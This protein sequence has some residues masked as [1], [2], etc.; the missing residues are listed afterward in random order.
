[1]QFAFFRG[2][3]Q[4]LNCDCTFAL[5]SIIFGVNLGATKPERIGGLKSPPYS[6][7]NKKGILVPPIPPV[8]GL[9]N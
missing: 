8:F 6:I 2:K 1:V 3:V 5:V 4:V 9:L 7:L